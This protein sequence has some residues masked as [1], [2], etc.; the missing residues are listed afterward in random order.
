MDSLIKLNK[1]PTDFWDSWERP[2]TLEARLDVK[3]NEKSVL[4]CVLSFST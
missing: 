4:L 3:E 1:V 2:G